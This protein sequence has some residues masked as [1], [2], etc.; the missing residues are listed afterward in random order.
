[1]KTTY[2]EINVP[3]LEVTITFSPDDVDRIS[4]IDNGEMEEFSSVGIRIRDALRN[5]I[6]EHLGD[7]QRDAELESELESGGFDGDFIPF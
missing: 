1:M 5:A 6:N 7:K 2:R 3:K 4:S